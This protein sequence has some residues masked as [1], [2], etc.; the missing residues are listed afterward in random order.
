[1]DYNTS[2]TDQTKQWFAK[3]IATSVLLTLGILGVVALVA[4]A[5]RANIIE[6]FIATHLEQYE[7]RDVQ[8][9][10]VERTLNPLSEEA[11]IVD[12]VDEASPA[13]VSVVIT[14]DVPVI[15]RY[16]EEFDPFGFGRGFSVPRQRQNG[17][18]KREVGGGSAFFVSP[19]GLLVTNRH[20]V[21]DP[22]AEY[23]VITNSG[24]TFEVEVIAR[25]TTLDIAILKVIGDAPEEYGG[26]FHYIEFGDSESLVP[27]QTA[28]AIGN[29]LAEFQNSVS[30][31]VISGLSRSI[32]AGSR[33]GPTEQ[34]D[35]VIQTDAAINPGNSGGP[36]LD[37]QGKVI[38]VN[39][40]VAAGSENI[41][42]ALP[43]NVV[44]DI[45]ASV[46]EFGEIVR[47]FL[48]VRFVM[49]NKQIAEE[50]ELDTEFGA[51]VIT[52]DSPMDIAVLPGSAADKAGIQAGDVI[53]EIDGVT[54][55]DRMLN[56]V[57]RSK[58]IGEEIEIVI[59]RDG[60]RM[61][62]TVIL[63]KAPE[64]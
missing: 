17:T 52:G 18:E 2:S 39:V 26:E 22:N 42:F 56:S 38:G 9:R 53:L 10:G 34:L 60:K 12:I 64:N 47:P 4:Y 7:E 35:E 50:E 6:F 11:T 41:G 1:M 45:V 31:G 24:E 58:K 48:G 14:K 25:D 32:M 15:E 62:K 27:G 46:E 55:E 20:V 28:I 49:L 19:D 8:E 5:N 54:L 43:G 29:A 13:V 33:F 61:T 57:I 40:A 3:S 23:S 51:Y 63:E 16:F 30:V 44:A 21:D 59:L 36:L 37:S